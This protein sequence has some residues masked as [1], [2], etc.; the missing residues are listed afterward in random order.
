MHIETYTNLSGKELHRQEGVD[1]MVTSGN[2]GGVMALKCKSYRF[3]SHSR[4]NISHLHHLHDSGFTIRIYT[5][6]V[7]YG[8]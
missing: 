7:V 3:D 2:L 6:Y 1:R 8:C 5:R 4:D